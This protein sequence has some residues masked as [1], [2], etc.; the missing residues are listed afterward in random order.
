[1]LTKRE[2]LLIENALFDAQEFLK[3]WRDSK[4]EM[5]LD[6]SSQDKEIQELKDLIKKVKGLD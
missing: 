5:G 2:I 6:Y 4:K 3:G 1:M